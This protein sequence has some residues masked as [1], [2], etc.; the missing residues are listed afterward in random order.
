MT[1]AAG[2]DRRVWTL[3][4]LPKAIEILPSVR[5][6]ADRLYLELLRNVPLEDIDQ[7]RSTLSRMVANI[8]GLDPD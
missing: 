3:H 1:C 7:M 8:S 2:G 4:P 6:A 5:K